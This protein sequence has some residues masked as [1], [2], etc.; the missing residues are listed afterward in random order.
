MILIK[1]QI[2][3]FYIDSHEENCLIFGTFNFTNEILTGSDFLLPAN[4]RIFPS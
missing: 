2:N 3:S 1:K 4:V